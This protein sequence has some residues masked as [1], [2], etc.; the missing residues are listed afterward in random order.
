M[1]D[2][3][4]D[5]VKA[6]DEIACEWNKYRVR[7]P[8]TVKK[9][10]EGKRGK[11]LDVGCGTGRN[12]MKV[13]GLEWTGTDI[14]DKMLEF[15][16]KAAKK[17]KVGVELIKAPASKLP[18]GDE[19]FDFVLSYAVLHCVNSEEKRVKSVEEIYRVLKKGGKALISSWGRKSP[20]LKNKDK[21]CSIAW[22]V[23]DSEKKIM[24]YTYVYDLDELVELCKK[25]GFKIV[26]SW[27]ERNVNIIVKK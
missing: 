27:E 17:K 14:S 15:A 21:E 5:E 1:C 25:V 7:I 2:V 16:G 24:R 26:S 19:S 12:F 18:F 4:M 13:D 8:P 20:R 22:G 11:I 10:L 9:F 3:Y 23:R 6:W